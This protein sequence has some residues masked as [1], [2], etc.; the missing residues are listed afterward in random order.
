MGDL[1]INKEEICK[2]HRLVFE[3]TVVET[4]SGNLYPEAS[5]V[6]IIHAEANICHLE[7]KLM[8]DIVLVD[9][10]LTQ[11]LYY[12]DGENNILIKSETV[13]IEKRLNAD[14][15]NSRMVPV[16]KGKVLDIKKKIA[17][18]NCVEISTTIEL[19]I[20][21]LDDVDVELINEIENLPESAKIEKGDIMI[22]NIVGEKIF[23]EE[24]Q[25]KIEL[26]EKALTIIK[27]DHLLQD[28]KAMPKKDMV[29][30][31]GN[32][33]IKIIYVDVNKYARIELKEIPFYREFQ[34]AGSLPGLD[35]WVDNEIGSNNFEAVDGSANEFIDKII[36][37]FYIKV[38]K[39]KS[40]EFVTDVNG[41]GLKTEKKS[42][43]VNNIIYHLILDE[44]FN[45]VTQI[46]YGINQVLDN[47]GTLQGLNAEICNGQILINGKLKRVL[48]LLDQ[49]DF[50][51]I[52]TDLIPINFKGAVPVEGKDK[53]IEVYPKP[54][55]EIIYEL[56]DHQTIEERAILGVMISIS[57][58]LILN[59]VSTVQLVEPP[60]DI[61]TRMY[62]VQKGDTLEVISRRFDVFLSDIL[63]VNPEIEEEIYCG[64]K[65]RIPI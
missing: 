17:N 43:E 9:G 50:L 47:I 1:I 11:T 65:I 23:Q 44:K 54:F 4:Y 34:M 56:T 61:E 46:P 33:Q 2:I 35:V 62:I 16:I 21:I 26:P 52:S 49:D 25:Q 58:K 39:Y 6:D 48:F 51:R 57:E 45:L 59:V 40:V 7:I 5:F 14:K 30:I 31:I 37:N 41:P 19:L 15:V 27:V 55:E 28:V 64:Q 60:P 8:K 3:S 29:S 38:F 24:V 63:K 12:A 13:K 32:M 18:H 42:V 36:M 20:K 53:I 10:L 22:E